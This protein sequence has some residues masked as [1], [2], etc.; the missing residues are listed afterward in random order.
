M[1]ANPNNG[2]GSTE[3]LKPFGANV[4]TKVFFAGKPKK[5]KPEVTPAAGEY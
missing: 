5:K 1:E 2:P 3:Y 4:Q